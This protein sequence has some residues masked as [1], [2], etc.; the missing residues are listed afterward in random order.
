MPNE[1]IVQVQHM[2]TTTEKYDGIV[3]TDINGNVL[4]EQFNK[5]MDGMSNIPKHCKL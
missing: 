1:V 3:F 2:A 4:S 5:D